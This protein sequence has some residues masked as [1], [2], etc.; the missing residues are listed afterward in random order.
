MAA[1][2]IFRAATSRTSPSTAADWPRYQ[3]WRTEY[4][5]TS[6]DLRDLD[7]FA[8][9]AGAAVRRFEPFR[10]FLTG[11]FDDRIYEDDEE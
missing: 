3:F 1:R 2:G 4:G 8:E 11:A 7:A 6:D 10:Q 9:A 5:F